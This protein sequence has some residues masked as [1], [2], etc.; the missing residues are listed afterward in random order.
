MDQ[1]ETDKLLDQIDLLA[2]TQRP[3]DFLERSDEIGIAQAAIAMLDQADPPIPYSNFL[4]LP[5]VIMAAPELVFYYHNV[6]MVPYRS[7][8]DI[9][10]NVS[11]AEASAGL[12]RER[13]LD[14]A[15][16]LNHV[17]SG[18]IIATGVSRHR[19]HELFFGNL[20]MSGKTGGEG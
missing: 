10:L 3:A 17:V 8:K 6:A 20:G 12:S 7:M 1:H 16:F 9:G 19:H 15:S 14:I 5:E 2:A 4:C 13:A 18:L 11:A